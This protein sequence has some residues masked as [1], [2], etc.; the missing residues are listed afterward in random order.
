M[1][2]KLNIPPPS[3]PRTYTGPGLVDIQLNGFAGIDFNSDP[4]QWTSR[5]WHTVRDA[6]RSCGVL[7]ALPTFITDSVERT[8]ARVQM[9]RRFIET[10]E[11]LASTFPA[12]HIEGPFISALDGPRGAHQKAFCRI[13]AQY[14]DFIDQLQEESGSR[15]RILTLAPELEGAI[16]LIERCAEAG[17]IVA[18]GHTAAARKEIDA[19][20]VAGASLS[21]H[22]GNGSHQML[23]RLDNY[24]QQQLAEDRLAATFI[25][26]GHHIPFGTLKNFLR[27]K[28]L[29]HSILITDAISAAGAGTGLYK[30]GE[31]TVEVDETLR[32]QIPGQPNLAGSALT[33]DRAIINAARHCGVPFET[34]WAM[35]STQPAALIGLDIPERISVKITGDTFSILTERNQV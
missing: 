2:L 7:H 4:S 8:I 21:T 3:L 17:I 23:P 12:L 6:L 9:Y 25:A 34:A 30:L 32:C 14:P 29:D 28:T 19:A 13:P 27:A 22:L 35:A 26:D 1:V 15:I 24:V 18:I 31:Q 16:P 5:E 20:V 33:L 11:L 10:D